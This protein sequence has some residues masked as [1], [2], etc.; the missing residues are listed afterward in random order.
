MARRNPARLTK[1]SVSLPF[2]IGK[3]EW[4]EDP[5]QRKAAWELYVELMTRIAVQPLPEGQGL[6]REALSSLHSL[7]PSTRDILRKAGPDVGASRTSVGGIA[8]RVL[9][10][11]LR[12]FL[13]KWQPELLAWEAGRQTTESPT[14][15]EASWS[16]AGE[17]RSELRTIQSA[18]A[19]YA[20][21]LAQIAGVTD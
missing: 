4:T 3:A 16:R 19:R 15:H 1:V 20:A 14:T 17:L 7:F 18:L 2:G 9:N 8:I 13:T 6:L 12:P 10:N 21:A 11:G 5:T